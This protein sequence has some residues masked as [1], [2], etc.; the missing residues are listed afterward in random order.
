MEAEIG[1]DGSKS[2]YLPEEVSVLTRLINN[3]LKHESA[4]AE[5]LPIKPDSD[6]LF[7]ACADGLV[8]IY[9]LKN[10]DPTLVNMK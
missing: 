4:I 10:I 2:T 6:D 8:L 9:L 1:E 7:D 3:T 5:R